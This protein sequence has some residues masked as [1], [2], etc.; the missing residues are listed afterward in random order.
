MEGRNILKL[1]R[2]FIRAG[3]HRDW[4]GSLRYKPRNVEEEPPNF[5]ACWSSLYQ[6]PQ[7]LGREL[8]QLCGGASY[9][10]GSIHPF[11]PLYLLLTK[12]LLTSAKTN[13]DDPEEIWISGFPGSQSSC[14]CLPLIP[15]VNR[16]H[17]Q[18]AE[19]WDMWKPWR[20]EIRTSM[21]NQAKAIQNTSY[22]ICLETVYE[23]TSFLYFALD[24][25][26]MYEKVNN[27]KPRDSISPKKNT[28][29]LSFVSITL[30]VV[31]RGF[32]SQKPRPLFCTENHNRMLQAS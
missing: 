24:A 20:F 28:T 3:K 14:K 21:P 12:G 7:E 10:S 2:F 13:Y 30:Q 27:N 8:I 29:A 16:A 22:H 17:G 25:Y 26:E 5:L 15:D 1:R 32:P 23:N 11:W 9:Q 31:T 6:T 18:M 19:G 4:H